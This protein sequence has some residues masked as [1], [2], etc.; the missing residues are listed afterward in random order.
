MLH[1]GAMRK[2]GGWFHVLLEDNQ[3]F[4]VLEAD[5]LNRNKYK[6][7]C[8]DVTMTSEQREKNDRKFKWQSKKQEAE[9]TYQ[10]KKE[11]NAAR[12]KI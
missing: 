11:A 7:K 4:S 2:R 3:Q 12:E 8:P 10:R 9:L 5:L 1:G 6:V